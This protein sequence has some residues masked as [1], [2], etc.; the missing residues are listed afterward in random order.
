VPIRINLVAMTPCISQTPGSSGSACAFAFDDNP[1]KAQWGILNFPGGWPT[2]GIGPS[3][4]CGSSSE[5]EVNGYISGTGTAF[6]ATVPPDPGY[7][8]VCAQ[9]GLRASTIQTI[10]GQIAAAA[11]NPFYLT[12]PVMSATQTILDLGGNKQAVPIVGFTVLRILGAW[13]GQDAKAHC[14]FPTNVSNSSLF[15][16]QTQ[17]DGGQV[18]S[19]GIPGSGQD[20]GV[21][22]IRLV[23]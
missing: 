22:G 6:T 11:P 2:S 19:G 3:A 9:S 18:I 7:V 4:D 1:F 16:I 5:N 10:M 21:R 20:F 15:C 13:N 23:G 17:W 12:F 8:Y 14:T